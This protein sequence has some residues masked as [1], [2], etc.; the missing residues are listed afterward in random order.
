MKAAKIYKIIGAGEYIRKHWRIQ[1][2]WQ[3][4]K[5]WRIQKPWRIQKHWR[6]LKL[7]AYRN[8]GIWKN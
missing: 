1:K 5:H 6:M 4:Q 3:I 2:P 8:I 7:G